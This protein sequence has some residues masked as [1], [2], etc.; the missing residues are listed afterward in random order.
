MNEGISL[1]KIIANISKLQDVIQVLND[2]HI[3]YGIYAGSYVY[4]VTS[5]RT[6][7]DVDILIADEDFEKLENLFP[8]SLIKKMPDAIFLYPY[9]DKEIEL[10]ANA[11]IDIETSHY[12]FRLT[13]LAWK[14]TLIL[15]IN[16]LGVRLCNPVDTILLKAIL[17]RG[18]GEDKHDLEDIDDLVKKVRIEKTYLKKRLDQVNFDDRILRVLKNFKLI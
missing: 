1:K 9:K 15:N 10:M 7:T 14:N 16:G 2:N 12:K 18:V 17:Q 11:N 13:D 4:I 3:K 5:K 8:N 6:P